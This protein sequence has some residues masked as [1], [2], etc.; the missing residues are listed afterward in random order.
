M[1]MH[2]DKE[3]SSSLGLTY[4]FSAGLVSLIQE[5][6]NEGLVVQAEWLEVR[7]D[8]HWL[9]SRLEAELKALLALQSVGGPDLLLHKNDRVI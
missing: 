4:Q 7:A 8:V 5:H 1:E 3:N 9:A 6:Q 2:K